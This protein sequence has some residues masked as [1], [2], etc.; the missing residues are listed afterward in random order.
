MF[1]LYDA[2]NH[3]QDEWL[4]PHRPLWVPEMGR[5]GLR[6]AVVNGTIEHDWPGVAAL[7]QE[8]SWVLPSYGLHPWFVAQRTHNWESK[9]AARLD[10]GGC[11]VGEIGL[12]RWKEPFDF[13]DQQDVFRRQLAMAA[14]RNLPVTIHCL[15]AWGALESIL[16][17]DPVPERGFLLHAYGG[18]MEMVRGFAERGAYFSF[19]GYFLLP[20]KEETRRIFRQIPSDRLLVET[21]APAMPVPKAYRVYD[22]PE[23]PEGQPVN[24]PGN[25]IAAYAGLA[26]IR[27]ISMGEL[28]IAVEQNFQ[29]LFHTGV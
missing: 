12:D 15:Q 26:E 5:I 9:L 25:L 8:H 17:S 14:E 16:K 1:P 18:P 2:H 28:A 10:A 7:A 21:D 6:R 20:R 13:E 11:A 22:L 4:A 3:L 27:S 23:S 19:S 24:H 29:R